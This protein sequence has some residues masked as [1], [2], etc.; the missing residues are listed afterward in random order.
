M[1]Y[2]LGFPPSKGSRRCSPGEVGSG[3]P[4]L[5]IRTQ[6]PS[7]R[8]AALSQNLRNLALSSRCSCLGLPPPQPKKG[9]RTLPP[10]IETKATAA[11]TTM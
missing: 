9:P 2:N 5:L 4:W 10:W 7:T 11:Y 6:P 8:A 1:E 3:T